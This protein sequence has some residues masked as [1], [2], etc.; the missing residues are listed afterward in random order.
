MPSVLR[1]GAA[2]PEVTVYEFY[3]F[4]CPSCRMAAGDVKALADEIPGLAVGLFNNPILS[5]GSRDAACVEDAVRR[6]AGPDAAVAL[7]FAM[8]DLRGPVTL[9]RALD[10]AADRGHDRQALAESAASASMRDD[11]ARR[12]R[13]AASLGFAVTP[14]FVAGVASIVGYPGPRSFA[15]MV[16]AVRNCSEPVCR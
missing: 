1:I 7:H 3:D 9:Q 13:F 4:N 5:P 14:T 12:L 11:V 8:W 10:V 6:L 2:E 15:E 16:E